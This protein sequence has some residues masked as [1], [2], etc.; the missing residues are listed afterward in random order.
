MNKTAKDARITE[1]MFRIDELRCAIEWI[2]LT[3]NPEAIVCVFENRKQCF[4]DE[5]N[6]LMEDEE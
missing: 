3:N 6:E 4:I 2:N 1:L 5:I